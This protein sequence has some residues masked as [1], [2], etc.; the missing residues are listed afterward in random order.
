MSE[1]IGHECGVALVRLLKPLEYFQKHPDY[2]NPLW[3][4]HKLFLLMEKQHNRGHDGAGIGALKLNAPKGYPYLFRERQ[5][6]RNSLDI[7]FKGLARTLEKLQRDGKVDPGN[8]DSIKQ[9]FDFG[10]EIY[11]GHLRYATSGSYRR[12]ACHPYARR[13]N[14]PT[15]TLMLAGNFN[16]TNRDHLN[17]QLIEKGQHPI[18]DTDTQALIEELGF[19]L[20]QQHDERYRAFCKQG[21]RGAEIAEAISRELDILDVIRRAS[22]A[23][24]G[25]YAIIG[26]V[27]NGEAFAVRDPHAIRPLYYFQSEEVIALASERAPLMSVFDARLQDVHEVEPATALIIRNDGTILQ[28]AFCKQ[29]SRKPCSFERIYFSRG[30]DF[31][32]YK[33]RKR[34]GALLAELVIKAVNHDLANTVFSFVPNTAE[35]AFFGMMEQ[36]RLNRRKEVKQA[37][38]NAASNGGITEELL[39]QIIMGHWPQAEKVAIKDI[40]LRTF[41]SEEKS[42][43]QLASHVYDISY[44]ACPPGANLVCVDD[45][46]VRGTTLRRSIIKILAKLNPQKIIIAST[47]PQIRY[48][49]CYG[50]DMSQLSKFIAFQAAIALLKERGEAGL[51]EEVYQEC[52]EQASLPES[53]L[54]NKVKKIYANFSVTEISKKISE[55]VTPNMADWH[56]EVQII[57]Q[58][59]TN[60]H[61]ALPQHT[62]DWYFTG[63][64]PTPGGYRVVNQ[65]FINYCQKSD[66]RS[67]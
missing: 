46:I 35:I 55:L 10:A 15:K 63:N 58:S 50:I 11:L 41:I 5:I 34:L 38:L 25:A 14:W 32:I 27:G 2:R 60:L 44:G 33:E 21:L 47:A 31:D 61:K 19:H 37:I 12:R 29:K 9:H 54:E 26:L 1:P 18:F 23:W 53:Q 51:I 13:S 49:D 67:Y 3:G 22:K 45:S 57:Y 28:E 48:P 52:L 4:F 42:R 16:I 36:L 64:Y 6:K 65:A 40:K 59:I 24:D 20:D 7:I 66:D 39:D 17:Q 8:A 43:N 30:N 56:G 62:G